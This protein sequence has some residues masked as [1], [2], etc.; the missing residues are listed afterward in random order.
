LQKFSLICPGLDNIRPETK[1]ETPSGNSKTHFQL[2]LGPIC[3][4]YIDQGV[5]STEIE[6]TERLMSAR[7]PFNAGKYLSNMFSPRYLYLEVTSIKYFNLS[8][9]NQAFQKLGLKVQANLIP[10]KLVKN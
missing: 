6:S 4:H 7:K 10:F 3:G 1:E 5:C 2:L 8:E 9:K